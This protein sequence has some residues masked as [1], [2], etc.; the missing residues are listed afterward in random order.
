MCVLLACFAPVPEREADASPFPP[1]VAGPQLEA[2]LENIARGGTICA[3]GAVGDYHGNAHGIRGVFQ[4]VAK[5]LKWEGAS[6]SSLF[7]SLPR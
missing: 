6:R 3:I 4:V 7:L 1:Q 2:A 5:E